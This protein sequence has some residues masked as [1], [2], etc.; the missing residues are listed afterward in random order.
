[1]E[2]SALLV[3]FSSMLKKTA[4]YWYLFDLKLPNN[5]APRFESLKTKPRKSL[6]NSWIPTRIDVV[7]K[8]GE[9]PPSLLLPRRNGSALVVSPSRHSTK[10]SSMELNPSK[11]VLPLRGSALTMPFSRAR[12][13]LTLETPVTLNLQSTGLNEVS[14]LNMSNERMKFSLENSCRPPLPG[15]VGSWRKLKKLSLAKLRFMKMSLP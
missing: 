12:R 14:P 6:V 13:K 8:K 4:L 3:S 1:M 5:L 15:R 9:R 7:S 2:L 10:A 11:R